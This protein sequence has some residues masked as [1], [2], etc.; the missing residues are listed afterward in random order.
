MFNV[1]LG[2]RAMN[3]TIIIICKSNNRYMSIN[4]IV[5]FAEAHKECSDGELLAYLNEIWG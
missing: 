4:S 5:D 3:S 1:S 2:V